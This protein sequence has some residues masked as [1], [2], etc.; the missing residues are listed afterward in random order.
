MF[1]LQGKRWKG[2]VVEVQENL[3]CHNG[4]KKNLVTKL[5]TDLE[6]LLAKSKRMDANGEEAN[7]FFWRPEF[8]QRYM[9]K[10]MS[11]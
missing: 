2:K 1:E 8:G 3:I 7:G 4:N 11:M 5:S 6:E 9:V 10:H